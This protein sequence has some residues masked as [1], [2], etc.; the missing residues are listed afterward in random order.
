[1]LALASVFCLTVPGPAA[2]AGR[3]EVD[4]ELVIATDVSGS[5]DRYE[6]YLQRKGISDAF[7]SREVANAIRMGG[8]GRIAVVYMEFSS[9]RYNRVVIDWR[10]LASEKDAADFGEELMHVAVARGEGT[11]LSDAIEFGMQLLETN[12]YDAVRRTID[13]SGDGPNNRGRPILDVRAEAL[14]KGITINGLPIIDPYGGDQ[15]ANLDKYFLACVIGGRGAFIQV[16]NGFE[17]FARAMRR[18]LVLEISDVAPR[19]EFRVI[20]AAEL[21][22]PQLTPRAQDYAPGCATRPQF[23]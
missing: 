22:R 2:A 11:S 21:P 13:L 10:V 3:T 18:K 5:I 17:D 12:A 6:A 1:M 14:A 7:R 4:L 20:R 23:F 16:A 8:L 9:A 19:D 15:S